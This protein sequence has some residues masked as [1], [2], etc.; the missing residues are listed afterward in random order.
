MGFDSVLPSSSL[1]LKRHNPNEGSRWMQFN[2]IPRT[3]MLDDIDS[4]VLERGTRAYKDIMPRVIQIQGNFVRKSLVIL[5]IGRENSCKMFGFYG[6]SFTREWHFEGA[7][8][9]K[10][11]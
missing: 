3:F 2:V 9:S 10:I 11:W 1:W 5:C 8:K 6:N 4:Q 7:V